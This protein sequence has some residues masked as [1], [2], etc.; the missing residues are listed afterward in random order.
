M[1]MD[2][3]KWGKSEK[4]CTMWFFTFASGTLL[5][6]VQVMYGHYAQSSPFQ[7]KSEVS[8]LGLRAV[9]GCILHKTL[10]LSCLRLLLSLLFSSSLSNQ[11]F[12][13]SSFTHTQIIPKLHF[14]SFIESS[15]RVVSVQD[16]RGV[17]MLV[18]KGKWIGI[19]MRGDSVPLTECSFQSWF[20]LQEAHSH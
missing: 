20:P 14:F 1:Y 10:N 2:S 18:Y 7:A 9:C 3:L 16:G 6:S 17:Y 11:I 4:N 15:W 8:I 5:F 13:L 12:I 19:I